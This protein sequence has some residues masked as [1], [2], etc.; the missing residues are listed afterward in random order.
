[1]KLS[2]L[3]LVAPLAIGLACLPALSQ[4]ADRPVYKMG[5]GWEWVT[6]DHRTRIESSR[7]TLKVIEVGRWVRFASQGDDPPPMTW[8]PDDLPLPGDSVNRTS[9][10]HTP[11][12]DWPLAVGKNWQVRS[13]W[14]NASGT[15]GKTVQNATVEAIEEVATPAGKFRAFR[16]VMTGLY[17]LFYS[18]PDMVA[19][20]GVDNLTLWYAPETG[21]AVRA[22]RRRGPIGPPPEWTVT[23]LVS[24]HRN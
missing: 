19:R 10:D 16:I 22:I 14:V 17:T 18:G 5:D 21:V 11:G 23:E 1:M 4:V 9:A 12:I 3:G 20:S 6:S 15:P 8:M 13:A 7:S 2:F 24:W